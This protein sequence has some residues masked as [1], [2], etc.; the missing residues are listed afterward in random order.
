MPRNRMR[1]K[2]LTLHFIYPF[3]VKIKELLEEWKNIKDDAPGGDGRGGFFQGY[4]SFVLQRIRVTILKDLPVT[5]GE[6]DAVLSTRIILLKNGGAA[7]LVNL[8]IKD[9]PA[10]KYLSAENVIPFLSLGELDDMTIAPVK[11]G[12]GPFR[13][14]LTPKSKL[15]DYYLA[16]RAEDVIRGA[17]KDP[18]TRVALKKIIADSNTNGNDTKNGDRSP[19]LLTVATLAD[20][21]PFDYL[22]HLNIDQKKHRFRSRSDELN[23]SDLAGMLLRAYVAPT[24]GKD[25]IDLNYTGFPE[26][27]PHVKAA[28]LSNL[29]P[30]PHLYANIHFRSCLVIHSAKYSQP[31]FADY[32]AAYTRV[33]RQVVVAEC[34][35]W[36]LYILISSRLDKLLEDNAAPIAAGS[37]SKDGSP[38]SRDPLENT[39]HDIIG[40]RTRAALAFKDTLSFQY[41]AGSIS[42]LVR[43]TTQLFN[44]DTLETAIRGKLDALN[45][46]YFDTRELNRLQ[47][48]REMEMKF[49]S[50]DQ[51]G[52]AR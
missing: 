16:T 34:T 20:G 35:Q 27:F 46:M 18:K 15:R 42:H 31:E 13:S 5:V 32:A 40:I 12:D 9:L 24:T 21:S 17:V 7:C 36:Y 45:R 30:L 2:S 4:A 8:E 44:M 49:S 33:L 6:Y 29:Y 26:A 43:R 3:E 22:H 19:Y 51:S 25:G 41:S 28:I 52:S 37:R 23:F 1:F 11:I 39:L 38:D 14:R 50:Q 47:E 10:K 48:V